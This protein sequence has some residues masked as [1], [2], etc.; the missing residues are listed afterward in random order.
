MAISGKRWRQLVLH[1][2]QCSN[3][4]LRS[5]YNVV[6]DAE[7]DLAE[8]R[9]ERVERVTARERV[10]LLH[11]SESSRHRADQAACSAFRVG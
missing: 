8:R 9:V 2:V 1:N 3:A 10:A 6:A 11:V 7:A 5:T 4:P